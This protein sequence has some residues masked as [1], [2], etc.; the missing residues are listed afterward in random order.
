MIIKLLRFFIRLDPF[1]YESN[2]L[3]T[4]TILPVIGYLHCRNR[5]TNFS[6]RQNKN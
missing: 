1:I 6:S 4:D 2:R 5:G 3:D